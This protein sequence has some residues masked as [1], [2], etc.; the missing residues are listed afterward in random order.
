M[1]RLIRDEHIILKK[2]KNHRNE[3]KTKSDSEMTL[4][5]KENFKGCQSKL[6]GTN[7]WEKGKLGAWIAK[8]ITRQQGGEKQ[9]KNT[10]SKRNE[11]DRPR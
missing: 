9:I 2:K 5:D 4:I 7:V 1:R 11:S 10:I 6:Q 8:A 3:V